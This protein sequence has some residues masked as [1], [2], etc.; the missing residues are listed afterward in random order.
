MSVRTLRE[1]RPRDLGTVRQRRRQLHGLLLFVI[2]LLAAGVVLFSIAS[3]ALL[4][5]PLEF[6]D[7]AVV[8]VGFVALAVAFAV[9]AFLHER[10]LSRAERALVDERVLA[11]ALSSRL[12]DLTALTEA[13][14]AVASTLSQDQVYQVILESAQDLLGATEASVMLLDPETRVLRIVASSGLDESAMRDGVAMLGDGVAGWVAESLQPVVLRGDVRDDRFK[15][16]I[17]KDRPV[18]SAMSVP[19]RAQDEV[20]GVINVSVSGAPKVYSEHDLRAL[21]A[22]AE[23]AATALANARMYEQQRKTST[24]LAEL[25]R[26]RRDFLATLTHDLKTPLT[27]ILG[28]VKLLRRAGDNLNS[29]QAHQFTDVI[30]RQGKRILEMVEQLVEATRLEEGAPALAREPLDLGRIVDEQVLAVGG[31]LGDRKLSVDMPAELPETYG[32]RNA[33]EHI[34][35]N[36]LENAV[37]YTSDNGTIEITVAPAERE[38]QV[39]VTDDGAGIPD[40]E[41]PHVFER[42]RQAGDDSAK[43]S[44]GLGLYIVRS[45]TQAHGGRVWAENIAGKGARITFTLPVRSR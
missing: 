11:T 32:D 25:E 44:V 1:I 10:R 16:F 38:V 8:R 17:P 45:L 39:S 15:A 21:T 18:S 43:G 6:L 41:L 2:V 7:L 12:R 35:M 3:E 9:Y 33:I 5:R 19:M 36:L 24:E 13:G 4:D 23:Q 26:Q 22:F 31:M 27:S 20:L 42:Y 14:R 37:K 40:K 29:E 28:Y 34:L 30:E